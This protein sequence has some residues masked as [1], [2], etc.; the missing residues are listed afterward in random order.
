VT[1]SLLGTIALFLLLAGA[2]FW[3][4][5]R[6]QLQAAWREPVLKTPVLIVESDDW[7]Y[8]PLE[9]AGRLREICALL[10]KHQDAVGRPAV[11]TLGVV[12]G[13]PDGARIRGGQSL[14]YHRMTLADERLASVREAMLDG[15]R[16]GVFSLQ[17][18]GMEH[19]WPATLLHASSSDASVRA[20]LKSEA[21]A[22]TEALPAHL[23][24]RWIDSSRLP[25]GELPADEVM[26]AGRDE[27]RAFAAI[28]GA[29]PAVA[30]PP[31]FVW[32]VDVERAWSDAGV[33]VLITP[34]RRYGS[35]DGAGK[36]QSTDTRIYNGQR[37]PG[38]LTYLVR[39]DYFEPMLGHRAERGLSALAAKAH[40]GR[41]T[42]LETHRANFLG[43]PALVERALG[44][45]DRLLAGARARFPALRFMSSAELARHYAQRSDL[46]ERNLAP[47]LRCFA[48]RLASQ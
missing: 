43:D 2:A 40:L 44:E 37:S 8:G 1:A 11:M 31:T 42:L 26:T 28:F 12:L 48:R 36:P 24:S 33:A 15:E 30:V 38:G 17:L 27:A 39:N 9:Q 35:R 7:G 46:I 10:L 19:F 21:P 20:W 4:A 22:P 47:R 32:S 29:P 45:L 41:P 14:A 5:F 23:Q 18:H 25:S 13:G 16:A 6:R 3:L 34:G